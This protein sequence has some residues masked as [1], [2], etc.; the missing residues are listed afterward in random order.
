VTPIFTKKE[1]SHR[2]RKFIPVVSRR[3]ATT[4]DSASTTIA[5]KNNNNMS[6]ILSPSSRLN[7]K[8]TSYN[9]LSSHLSAAS[10]FAACK[11]EYCDPQYRFQKL[12]E[13]L[14]KEIAS[15][16]VICL[17]E[18]STLWAGYLHPYF[19]KNGYHFVTGL[20]G[21]RFNG[22]MGV[23][24]AIPLAKYDITTVDITKVSDTKR[25]PRKQK[26]DSFIK[27]VLTTLKNW[28]WK[29]AETLRLYK[30]PI[31]M[32]DSA[33]YRHN[34]MI[35]TRLQCK[36]SKRSFVIGTY[37]MPCMFKLPSVMNIH[38]ALSAQHIQRFAKNDPFI[39]VGDFNIKP[40]SS[41]YELLT[42]GTLE[43]NV[44]L[45]SVFVCLMLVLIF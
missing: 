21:N 7:V 1:I 29:L 26:D 32:W 43:K 19:V 41:Q 25:M 40:E 27:K 31:D 22:Y 33:L 28:F 3:A 10:Y 5:T 13:K 4:F 2:L 24:V 15:N 8:V 12:Q 35:C 36:E 9:V 6:A 44:S 30:P 16:A 34:Q 42:R 39:Y 11:P 18:I 37:H 20:Y 17:Q 23:G 14:D 45:F 38:C